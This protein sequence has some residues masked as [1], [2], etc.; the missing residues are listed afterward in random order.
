MEYGAVK[1]YHYRLRKLGAKREHAPLAVTCRDCYQAKLPCEPCLEARDAWFK[2]LERLFPPEYQGL[3]YRH[4]NSKKDL[5][6]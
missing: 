6:R 4:A 5:V 2:D 3:G 1:Q